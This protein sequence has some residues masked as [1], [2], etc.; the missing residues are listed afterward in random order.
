MAEITLEQKESFLSIIENSGFTWGNF[1]VSEDYKEASITFL[2][3]QDIKCYRFQ[4]FYGRQFRAGHIHIKYRQGSETH[5]HQEEIEVANLSGKFGQWLSVINRQLKFDKETQ[6]EKIT[7]PHT[8]NSISSKFETIYRE[9][10]KAEAIELKEIC[11]MGYRKAFEFLLIDFLIYRNILSYDKA[12]KITSLKEYINFLKDE[13]VIHKLLGFTSWVGNEF[14]HYFRKHPDKEIADLKEMIHLFDDWI[15]STEKVIN[16]ENQG[17]ELN[18][19][20]FNSNNLK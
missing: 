20:L 11:G 7:F 15:L 10:A 13:D 1:H 16:V 14:C 9:A 18:D 8:I 12:E 19:K 2:W 4:A 5:N 17:R 3:L 6:R